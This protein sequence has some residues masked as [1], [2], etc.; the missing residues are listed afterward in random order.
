MVVDVKLPNELVERAKQQAALEGRSVAEQI[1]YW[2]RVGKMM[3]ENP[4]LP[5]GVIQQILLSDREPV[6]GEYL[7]GF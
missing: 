5:L 7:F 3:I 1:E 2:S 4:D 6:A